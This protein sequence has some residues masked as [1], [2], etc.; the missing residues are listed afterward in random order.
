MGRR[1]ARARRRGSTCKTAVHICYGYGIKANI[2]WKAGLGAEWRQYEAIFPALARSR[3]DQVSVECAGAKVPIELLG[4]LAGKD[5][6]LGAIDVASEHRETPGGRRGDDR[7]CARFRPGGAALPVHQLRHGADGP[8]A[9]GRQT[10]CP[11]RPE[12]PWYAAAFSR[13]GATKT[14]PSR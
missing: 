8:S 2:D 6:L 11:R 10:R 3:I 12:P 5:I 7:A 1:S 9:G 14:E 4:L 13:Y